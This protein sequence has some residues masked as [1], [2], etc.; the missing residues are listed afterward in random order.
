MTADSH[1]CEPGPDDGESADDDGVGGILRGDGGQVG[2]PFDTTADVR[3]TRWD[4]YGRAIDGYIRMPLTIMRQDWR[5]IV[6][7]SIVAVYLLMGTVLTWTVEPTRTGDGPQF[8]QPFETWEYPLGTNEMGQ[9][10]FAQ[11][12]HSTGPVLTMMASGAL[13]TVV[14]GTFFGLVAGYKGGEV[15]TVLS[16]ITD[17]F[18]NIPGLPLVI[19]LS[20]LFEPTHPISV[21]IL[22]AVAAWAGLARAIRS[23]VLAIRDES[24]VEAARMMDVPTPELLIK[25][26]LPHLMPYIMVNLVNAARTIIF[27]AVALYYLGVLPFADA[28]WGV[29]LNQA[30][31]AGAIYRPDATHWLVVPMV[32]IAGISIGLLLIAQSL[33]RVFNPRV[34]ARHA[35]TGDAEDGDG[36]EPGSTEMMKQV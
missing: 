8:V 24:F 21:G 17:V 15:D 28:N 36:T 22:L 35:D 31:H 5:S 30:Y 12:V 3:E 16:S 4:R 26:I 33:D 29:M 2:T 20:V 34:R 18:I 32:A 9:D 14:M 7:L 25:E 1:D 6:G 11:T 23:Q 13:F 19:V 10:L 27:S